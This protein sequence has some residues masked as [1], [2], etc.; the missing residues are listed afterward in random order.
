MLLSSHYLQGGCIICHLY[1]AAWECLSHV[2]VFVHIHTCFSYANDVS[3]LQ[4]NRDCLSLDGCW[5]L[6][7]M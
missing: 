7:I 4:S 3:I 2:C 1:V 5:L 6:W